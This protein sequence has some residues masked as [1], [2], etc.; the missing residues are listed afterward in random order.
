MSG[1]VGECMTTIGLVAW[2]VHHDILCEPLTE[3]IEERID[4]IRMNKPKEGIET[5]L[6]LLNIVK[7]QELAFEAWSEYDIIESK[8]FS[9]YRAI[10]S[11]AISDYHAITSKFGYD[12]T[13]PNAGSDYLDMTREQWSEYTAIESKARSEFETIISQSKNDF[14]EKLNA[15]HQEECPDCPWDGRTIFPNRIERVVKP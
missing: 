3:P 1:G 6:R 12:A 13:K 15:L 10:R 14:N 8:A 4:Y 2:H 11:K 9:D 7:N 5:R